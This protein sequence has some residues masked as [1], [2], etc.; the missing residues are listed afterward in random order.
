VPISRFDAGE[1]ASKQGLL[2]LLASKFASP[3]VQSGRLGYIDGLRAIAIIAVVAFHA[4]IPGFEGGFVGVD[5][6]FVISGFLITQ[7]I[8]GQII[9]GRFSIT[10]FYA[11]RILRILPPLLLV[12]CAT[13]AVAPLF[14]L[15]TLEL[16][17]LA[18]SAAATAAMISN[19]YF[20][21]G[22]EYF[23][24]RPETTPL[25]HTWSLGVEEQ[26]YLLAPALI[27]LTVMLALRRKW[28]PTNTLL[29]FGALSVIISCVV[30][31]ILTKTDH[32]LAFFSIMSRSWQFAV[33]GM[34]AIAVLNGLRIPAWARSALAMA[35]LFAIVA[36]VMF[37]NQEMSYPGFAAGW[38]PTIGALLLLASGLENEK[39]PLI[40]LLASRPAVAIGVLSYSWYLWHWPVIELARTLPVAEGGVWKDCAAS[41][42]ALLLSVPTY[43]FLERP[44]KALRRSDAPRQFGSRI[45]GIGVS[46]SIV[47]ALV[48]LEL[49]HSGAVD[50]HLRPIEAG[51]SSLPAGDCELNSGLPHF[52]G[53]TPCL[54][55]GNGP[56]RVVYWGDSHTWM[57][58]PVAYWSA[59]AQHQSAV[60][61]AG[62]TCPPLIGIEVDFHV[63]RFC[64]DFN[65]EVLAWIKAQRD[66]PITGVV[67]SARWAYYNRQETPSGDPELP[68]LAWRDGGSATTYSEML[69]RGLRDLI[70][71]LPPVR[72]LIVGP[73]PELEKNASLC[74]AR[75]ELN[76][77][78]PEYC[79]VDRAKV[80][81]RRRDAVGVLQH[82]VEQF[83]NTRMIDP[84]EVFCK[85]D[86]CLASDA[87]GSFYY[88][89]DHLTPLGAE[90][91]YR[92][93][94]S[95]FLWVNK[96]EK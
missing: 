79:G 59:R 20:T 39:A 37:F 74:L 88:D 19:Y 84:L 54:L 9:A 91:L 44:L 69:F 49:V 33:G 18:N 21:A 60:A 81:A 26:Y 46:G 14:P 38:V 32:R 1:I 41:A 64:A 94:E 47:V 40:K 23:G 62:T 17:D 5:V 96:S 10:E 80:Q 8:V 82:V 73:V 13:L 89:T 48:A 6:F 58:Q 56:P 36:A 77:Q 66:Y 11:R 2:P 57:L 83:P 63:H 90:L 43:I 70:G 31:A 27:A 92:H 7:Q 87:R 52:Q 71:A 51:Q 68:I 78:S 16:R 53:V 3:F 25:L 28:K 86:R 15:L 65:E 61:F 76:R 55:G 35:G 4:R 30:L 95:S 67:L 45:V 24:T 85:S 12:T 72:V 29:C 50:R 22:T 93:F 42:L 34:L 75:L